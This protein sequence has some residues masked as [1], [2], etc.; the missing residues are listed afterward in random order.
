MEEK[1]SVKVEEETVEVQIQGLIECPI[2]CDYLKDVLESQ[3][4]HT[5]YC[6]QCLTNWRNANS[7][8]PGCRSKIDVSKCTQNIP[9][10]RFVDSIP[11]AC[12]FK[13][14]GCPA[15]VPRSEL[16]KHKLLCLFRPEKLAELKKQ[17]TEELNRM[18]LKLEARE[19][20]L[21]SKVAR[22]KK[23]EKIKALK[24]LYKDLIELSR[25]LMDVGEYTEAL[26]IVERAQ[27]YC[28]EVHGTQSVELAECNN[29]MALI[30]SGDAKYE[31]ALSILE[32]C[33]KIAVVIKMAEKQ[34]EFLINQG[35]TLMKLA[36]YNE[37][38]EKFNEALKVKD[39]FNLSATKM[40]EIL[41]AIGLVAKK[42][43]KYD[44]GM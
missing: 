16:E 18:K 28:V 21:Q 22:I 33:V 42:R 30:L 3:C 9:I 5:L 31:K 2:C 35:N 11:F 27:K 41:N 7:T 36:K 25:S 10:Q 29:L 6:K 20:E 4:C 26:K 39:T 19:K 13:L 23:E 32:G 15:K 14:N 34:T 38:A 17:K 40:A 12:P 1:L 44:E 43:S 37:A 8:C 24:E